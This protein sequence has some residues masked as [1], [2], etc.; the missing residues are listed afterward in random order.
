MKILT[1]KDF[2][3]ILTLIKLQSNKWVYVVK[4]IRKSIKM[5]FL[6]ISCLVV[7]DHFNFWLYHLKLKNIFTNPL[8]LT[9]YKLKLKNF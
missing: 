7:K 3:R 9:L 5:L 1:Y 4:E 6:M 2:K 8:K